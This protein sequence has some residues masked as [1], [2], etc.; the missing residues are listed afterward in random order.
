M[1]KPLWQRAVLLSSSILLVSPVQ[2]NSIFAKRSAV[3]VDDGYEYVTTTS[4]LVPKRVKK[5]S[6]PDAMT[7]EGSMD[8]EQYRKTAQQIQST[9]R[10]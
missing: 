4:S 1:Q 8:L 7:P 10:Q 3:P 5:G 9:P 2:C 6:Q